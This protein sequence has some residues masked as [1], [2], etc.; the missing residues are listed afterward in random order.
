VYRIYQQPDDFE[1]IIQIFSPEDGG[2]MTP[3]FN[4]IRWDFAY[5]GDHVPTDGLFMIWPDFFNEK[6]DSLPTDQ[7]LPIGVGLRAR[8]TVVVDE[9]RACLH[10]ARISVGVA[11]YC[12]EGSK[13]VAAGTVTKI[14][15][16]FA[17]RSASQSSAA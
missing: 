11:F 6:G 17:E 10:R 9:M 7:P 12:H 3:P 14:T 8:M 16:L 4:G 2:R 15:G 1:A 13:R 5:A